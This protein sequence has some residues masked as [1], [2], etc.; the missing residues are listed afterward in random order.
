M[1]KETE[2]R[3]AMIDTRRIMIGSEEKE[4]KKELVAFQHERYGTDL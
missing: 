3:R 4:R 1:V 2:R